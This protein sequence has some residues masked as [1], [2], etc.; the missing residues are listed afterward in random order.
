LREKVRELV[1]QRQASGL[2]SVISSA[3]ANDANEALENAMKKHSMEM[4]KQKR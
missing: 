4:E 3:P 1:N 2:G